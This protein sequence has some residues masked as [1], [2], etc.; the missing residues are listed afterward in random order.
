MSHSPVWLAPLYYEEYTDLSPGG[1]GIEETEEIG[2]S[3]NVVPM[4][5]IE[6]A[7]HQHA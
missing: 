4:P 5:S 7:N 3:A 2:G 1:L 6:R